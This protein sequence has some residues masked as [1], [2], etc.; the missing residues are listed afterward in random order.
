MNAKPRALLGALLAATLLL[1]APAPARAGGPEPGEAAP[2]LEV[3]DWVGTPVKVADMREKVLLIL[4]M[5]TTAPDMARYMQSYVDM[6]KRY[7]EKGLRVCAISR[8][9]KDILLNWG[10]EH[11]IGFPLGTDGGSW[12]GAYGV[13]GYPF[14]Y[15]VDIWGEIAWKGDGNR[16]ESVIP[17]VESALREVKVI[18]VKRADTSKGFDKVWR[19][20]DKGDYG[21]AAKFLDAIAAGKDEKDAAHAEQVKKDVL[22]V[23]ASRLARAELLEKRLDLVSAEAILKNLEKSFAGLPQAKAAKEALLRWEKDETLQDE[24]KAQRAYE[25]GRKL[26]DARRFKEAGECYRAAM[27]RPSTRAAKRALGRFQDLVKK[28]LVRQ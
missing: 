16:V 1:A 4:F 2:E 23:A 17:A 20:L 26:E 22:A 28:G 8:E 27:A 15:I 25:Q 11:K 19:A 10:D 13:E 14:A 5:Q 3:K 9:N 21:Q 12:K 7:E 24:L 6:S 18:T